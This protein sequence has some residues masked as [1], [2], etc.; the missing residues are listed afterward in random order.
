MFVHAPSHSD[1]CQPSFQRE[2][3]ATILQPIP[4][5]QPASC[6]S[7]PFSSIHHQ[8]GLHEE[9]EEGSDT[10]DLPR[11]PH[12]QAPLHQSFAYLLC[13]PFV[14]TNKMIFRIPR[15]DEGRLLSVTSC[16]RRSHLLQLR[17]M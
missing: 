3:R 8:S 16:G 11:P 4:L 12:P 9:V 2:I 6:P 1:V 7:Q 13:K 14:Q 10:N 5:I 17:L 15:S